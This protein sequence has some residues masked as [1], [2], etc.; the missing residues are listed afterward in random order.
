[1]KKLQNNFKKWGANWSILKRNDEW[2]L[3]RQDWPLGGSNYNVCKIKKTSDC[4]MPNGK[5]IPAQ[6]M[7]P[8]AE[9]WGRIAWNFG[10]DAIGAE[11]KFDELTK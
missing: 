4:L 9:E 5:T 2:C 3:V 6:E 1:M 10:K 8:S 11:K 7:I